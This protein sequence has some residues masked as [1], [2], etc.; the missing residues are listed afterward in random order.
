M[1]L[2]WPCQS[3]SLHQAY[4]F[5]VQ[6]KREIINIVIGVY[7]PIKTEQDIEDVRADLI[8]YTSAN[9]LAIINFNLLS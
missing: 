5:T 1:T 7:K 8:E 4:I 3:L 6:T 9:N 2:V